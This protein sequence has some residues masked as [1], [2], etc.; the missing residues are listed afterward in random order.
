MPLLDL[1][2][3]LKSLRYGKDRV[4]GGSSNQP[5]IQRDLPDSL[6]EVGRTGGPDFLL[7]GGALVPARVGR[8]VSRLTQMFFDLK[9]P[10]GPLFIAKQNVL[11]LSSTDVTAGYKPL[12]L[13]QRVEGLSG[14][15]KAQDAIGTFVQN[16]LN[17]NKD[18][19]YTPLSTLAQAAGGPIGLHVN[20]QGLNPISEPFRYEEFY[21]DKSRL[22]SLYIDKLIGVDTDL[23]S[24]VGGPGAKLGVGRTTLRRYEN[25]N[26]DPQFLAANKGMLGY[27]DLETLS[28]YKRDLGR[29]STD[30]IDFRNFEVEQDFSGEEFGELPSFPLNNSKT[31]ALDYRTK[32]IEQRVNLGNP[33]D[34][35]RDKSKALDKINALA[36]YKADN[37]KT[38]HEKNDLVK[39]R[40]GIFDNDNPSKKTYL[41]F[42]AFLDQYS[43][44]YNANWDSDQFMGRGEQFYRYNGFTRQIS[45]GW[46]VAA[47]SRPELIPQYQK[48][49]YLASSLAP[50]FSKFGYMRGN[51]AELTIGGWLFNQP[52]I[53]TSMTLDVPQESPWEIGIST[54]E[55]QNTLNTGQESV[56]SDRGVKELP[57]IVKVTGFNFIPIH[58]FVPRLQQNTFNNSDGYLNKFGKE[59]Y[60][61]LDSGE[62]TNNYDYKDINYIGE[63]NY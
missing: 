34:K 6:S 23:Y 3:N 15:E 12:E 55:S 25:T 35:T 52:G 18:N 27:A 43:D 50:D 29:G 11:A 14:I 16:N 44:T 21:K 28:D 57:H 63:N 24:Y 45:L 53:I 2:T 47:Q 31:K 38:I 56:K 42:R 19:V 60:I 48:L 22:Q 41:H 33:A 58:T 5:Y 13:R 9:T 32:N 30:I 26:P 49:N 40:I 7:R 54:Q 36:M 4:G 61:A 17:F 8:D 37:A 46:T 20:K 39:F 59:R 10:N 1:R 62:K 51:L